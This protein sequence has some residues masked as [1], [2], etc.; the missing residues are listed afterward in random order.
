M[1]APLVSFSG[2]ASGFDYRSLVDAI[3]AQERQPAVR[4]ESRI[5]ALSN[6]QKAI[7]TF[8]SLMSTFESA[9]SALRD[10]T[11]FDATT[12]TTTIVSGTR[13]LAT[14]GTTSAVQQGNHTL[15]VSQLAR[16]AKLVGTGTATIGDP[17]GGAG[18]TISI[19]G[20]TID[21]TAD[22]TLAIVRDRIN[23]INT[24]A[25]P[26]GV[27]ATVLSV[28]STDH[29]LVL[30]STTTGAAG[31][32]LADVNGGVLQ[33]LGF[34]DGNGDVPGTA[35]LTE[36]T[37]AIFAIDGITMTR[38]SNVIADALEGITLTLVA[39]DP[40]AETA[41]TTGRYADATRNAMQGFV[42]GYNALVSF[43]KAQGTPS[44]TGT[45][46]LYN[47][48][49]VRGLRR[50]LPSTLLAGVFGASP[51]MATA[52][53]VGL[54][55]SRDGVLAL[56]ATTFN[57]AFETRYSDVRNLFTEQ[58]TSSSSELQFVSSASS[59]A[60][61]AWDVEITS[62][63]TA[64]TLVTSGFS[65]SY[66]AGA[67]A[68]EITLTDTRSGR[69]ASVALTTGMSTADIVTALSNA[70]AAEGLGIDVIA[71]GNEIRFNHRSTGA[72]SGISVALSGIGDGASE[73]WSTD[74]S[75]AGTDITGTIGG[76]AATGSGSVLVASS[77]SPVAGLTARY[78]GSTLGV[79][80]TLSL[81][82]G[83]GAAIERIL[84]R[85]IESGGTFD[86]RKSSID[87]QIVRANDR[88]VEIDGRLERRRANLLAR[89][90]AMEAAIARLQQAS[91][92]FLNSLN[93]SNRSDR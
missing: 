22:D 64:A 33:Q 76:Y 26:S 73:A 53:S 61:G 34:L 88:I 10:G 77:G 49:M 36:G 44:G 89:F 8:R 1:T 80:A 62:I 60:S 40:G 52:A 57:A 28:S 2:L 16:A 15:T 9:A 78:E 18:G 59:V 55:L 47:D 4:L 74:S 20:Q 69:Q 38:T 66:D 54:S 87:D 41:I 86:L 6:Q 24:G 90:V 71:E 68:D 12:S 58:R 3:I 17:I 14:V 83:T 75:V 35:V 48:S 50:D 56:D 42:D 46:A 39:D 29:R 63:A 91:S 51:D 79:V 65:G 31:I 84:D 27:T 13:A 67:T 70:I 30:T 45:P 92:G 5:T 32:T 11:A 23:A 19:N 81:S 93:P 85:Y 72:A 82:V 37:D 43:L 25:T 21:I 7:E